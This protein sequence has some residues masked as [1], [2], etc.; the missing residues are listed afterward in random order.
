MYLLWSIMVTACSNS[1]HRVSSTFLLEVFCLFGLG[2]VDFASGWRGVE[3]LSAYWVLDKG[4]AHLLE[5]V[6]SD[7]EGQHEEP[8]V[9]LWSLLMRKCRYLV[10]WPFMH[11]PYQSFSYQKCLFH[12][13][14]VNDWHYGFWFKHCSLCFAISGSKVMHSHPSQLTPLYLSFVQ[15]Y[16]H[17]SVSLERN[18]S[19]L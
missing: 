9:C 4:E 14:C 11:V 16:I 12:F 6:E 17:A 15:V 19:I 3:S 2:L 13:L 7:F 1:F 10:G 18:T 8:A 5:Q